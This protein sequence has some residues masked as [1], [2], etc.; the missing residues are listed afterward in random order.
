E[1]GSFDLIPR[2]P[3]GSKEESNDE[4]DQELR[5]S[6]EARIQKEE[7]A[8]ELYREFIDVVVRD[9]HAK[10]DQRCRG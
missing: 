6:E 8:D 7:E 3:E 2:T 1:E 4:E 10:P 5:L 9:K